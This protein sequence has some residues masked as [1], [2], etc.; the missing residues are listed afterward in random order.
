MSSVSLKRNVGA[1]GR[2]YKTTSYLIKGMIIFSTQNDMCS[3]CLRSLASKESV[4]IRPSSY[5]LPRYSC[6]VPAYTSKPLHM[7]TC[8]I[9]IYLL[10]T[11][12]RYGNLVNS[13]NV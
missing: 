4:L 8:Q 5:Y 13:R 12:K 11:T 9:S 7:Y 10:P 6:T 3:K 1:P 2:V